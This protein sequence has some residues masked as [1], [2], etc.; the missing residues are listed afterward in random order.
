MIK[1]NYSRQNMKV[2]KHIRDQQLQ[3]HLDG[4]NVNESKKNT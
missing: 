1:D 4:S 2:V 3:F